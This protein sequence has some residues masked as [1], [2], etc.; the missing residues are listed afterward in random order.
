[1]RGAR[2]VLNDR[3]DDLIADNLALVRETGVESCAVAADVSSEDGARAIVGAG[4]ERWG[5]VDILVNVAGGV[6]GPLENPIWEI[7]TEQ[8]NRTLAVNLDSV[9]QCTRAAIPS[10]MERRFGKIVN[11]ASTEWY[12]APMYV[13]YASAKAGVVAFTRSV[14]TQLGP[15]D[16]NVNAVAPGATL[17]K[18]AS[19]GS[20]PADASTLNPLGRINEPED[21]AGA[22]MF[23]VSPAA[24][25]VTGQL[26]TV[27]GGLNPSL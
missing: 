1:M 4:L 11:I 6:K 25:N 18:A 22:V 3:R 23:L 24:R 15:Y 16:I 9:F 10:M 13:H 7:T 14:A 2:I 20:F 26:L 17:T 8:W 27:A 12:G 19:R 5:R 21:I